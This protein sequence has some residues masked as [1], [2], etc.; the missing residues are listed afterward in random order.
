MSIPAVNRFTHGTHITVAHAMGTTIGI[1][2]MILLGTIGYCIDVDKLNEKKKKLFNKAFNLI[3]SSFAIFWLSLI[4]AGCIKGYRS[5]ILETTSF[6]EVMQ[7][8]NS[9]L[10]VFAFSAFGLATGFSIIIALYWQLARA[11]KELGSSL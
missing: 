8:V 1:N 4:V 6:Q 9:A 5:S 2:T 10:Y 7:P 3:Q 11:N